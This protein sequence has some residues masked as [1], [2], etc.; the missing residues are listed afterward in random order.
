[1]GLGDCLMSIGEAKRIHQRTGQPVLITDPRGMPVRSDLF[2]GV[3]YLLTKPERGIRYQRHVNSPGHR[4][5]IKLKTAERWYWNKYR[6]EPA[7]VV[8]TQAEHEFA[9]GI[10]RP[11]I[12]LEPHVKA[13]GHRNKDWGWT[14]WEDLATLLRRDNHRVIQM[15]RPGEKVLRHAEGAQVPEFRKALAVLGQATLY[16]GPEGGL[17]H[18]AAAMR[19]P[20]VVLFG[21]FISPDTTGY[22]NHA[23]LFAS[24]QACGLRTDCPGCRKAMQAIAPE[25]VATQVR[26]ML[27][28][29]S[30]AA[31]PH[32]YELR[33]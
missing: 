32:L 19:T 2:T 20:A 30:V 16:V 31:T 24:N 3:P 11:F 12:V 5:Y 6:P 26:S 8:L 7:D 22:A 18:G 33:S 29:G 17:H 25:E 23:N 21:E 14:H 10:S 15:V 4:P 9:E 1:M 27:E 13:V 28:T